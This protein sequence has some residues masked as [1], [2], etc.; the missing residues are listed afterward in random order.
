M[1]DADG[2]PVRHPPILHSRFTPVFEETFDWVRS[3]FPFLGVSGILGLFGKR[4]GNV[5][6]HSLRKIM[7][8]PIRSSGLFW[9]IHSE[10]EINVFLTRSDKVKRRFQETSLLGVTGSI[11]SPVLGESPMFQTAEWPDARCRRRMRREP[12]KPQGH[13]WFPPPS[14]VFRILV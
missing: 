4:G 2:R 6:S 10:S 13:R 11:P 9:P 1:P 12:R 8:V 14:W 7:L 3:P 5:W